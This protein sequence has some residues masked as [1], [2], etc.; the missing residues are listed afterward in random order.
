MRLLTVNFADCFMLQVC[1]AKMHSWARRNPQEHATSYCAMCYLPYAAGVRDWMH[2]WAF[3]DVM[4]AGR[5]W[6]A[7]VRAAAATAA[8]AVAAVAAAAV[9]AATAAVRVVLKNVFQCTHAQI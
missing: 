7:Q 2:S 9:A 6:L 4:K 1:V 8:A 3:V 5:G